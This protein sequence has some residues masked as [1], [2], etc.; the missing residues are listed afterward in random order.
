MLSVAVCIDDYINE[1]NVSLN[2]F[3]LI[4]LDFLTVKQQFVTLM[5]VFAGIFIII[6]SSGTYFLAQERQS[7]ELGQKIDV[8]HLALGSDYVGLLEQSSTKSFS[9]KI[10]HKWQALSF[11]S[12]AR[13]YDP[14]GNVLVDYV[15]KTSM[16]TSANETF[17]GKDTVTFNKNLYKKGRRVGKVEYILSNAYSDPL[18]KQILGFLFI[19]IATSLVMLLVLALVLHSLFASPL[20]ELTKAI[21]RTADNKVY[22]TEVNVNDADRSEFATLARSFNQLIQQ[23]KQTLDET[24]QAKAYAQ[25]LAYYDELTGLPNRRLLTQRMEYILDIAKRENK[26][27]ALF[28]I[29]LDNFKIL[30]DSRGHA[31]GDELLTQVANSLKDVF[32]SEDT[33]ARLG[34][35]E[36]IILSGHLDDSKEAVMN[37]IH[38]LMLKLRHT[39]SHHFTVQSET[40]HLTA[41]IGVTTFPDMGDTADELMKQ[42]DTAMYRAKESGRDGYHFYQMDM[43]AVADARLKM[44][45]EL[46]Q[47]I[48]HEEFELFYQPQVDEFGRIVGAEALLRWFKDEGNCVSPAEFIP[49]A[50]QTGLIVPIG[51]WVLRKSF[52]QLKEWSSLELG[53]NFNLSINIS[54]FQFHQSDFVS[55]VKSMLDETG[56]PVN[57]VTL[58]VTEGIVIKNIQAVIDKMRELTS[59]GIK[60]SMDDFGT[61]YSSLTYL[62]E[63]P[64]SELKIDQSF[65]RDLHLD[66]SDAEIAA[67]IIAMAKNLNLSVVA[68]GVEEESQLIF[69]RGKGCSIFQGYYFHKPMGASEFTKLLKGNV[70]IL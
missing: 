39:L 7:L 43:Q 25:E 6:F 57:K 18:Q 2:I 3:K 27:G 50:E 19:A 8:V 21:S 31:A 67:T 16:P 58:E 68:E 55:N 34:G 32:R 40:Y 49:V 52:L 17:L 48:L 69:L 13:L 5:L 10:L 46:R 14:A 28:F 1:V 45:S 24:Q 66:E 62:K 51:N 15:Q 29:D 61:G 11:I 47:A 56:V 41:S 33:V 44:E 20:K 9:P 26:Y 54:P 23:T 4:G 70:V 53:S 35:D 30:N 22:D 36:F 65:V 37:Q 64:L 38:S 12:R 42:A 59:L 60:I 63:L